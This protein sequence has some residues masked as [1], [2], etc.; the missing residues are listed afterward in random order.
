MLGLLFSLWRRLF[1]G[2]SYFG[3]FLEQRGVQFI[4]C[5]C[6]VFVWEFFINHYTWYIALIIGLLV[7][8]FWCKGHFPYF[9]CGTESIDYINQELEKG[10]KP[11]FFNLVNKIS[12]MF[13]FELWSKQWCFVGLTLRYVVFSLPVSLFVGW[14]FSVGALA[15]PFIYNAC[16]WLNF[17]PCKLA[18]SPTN[19]AEI[20]SGFII[21]WAL[22]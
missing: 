13:G 21:G 5:V 1:G 3:K 20:F 15:I 11:I 7:Y 22:Y 9:Q 19:Y 2:S 18:K 4:L 14:Q 17:P 12:A 10:R 6:L 16:F 8:Y